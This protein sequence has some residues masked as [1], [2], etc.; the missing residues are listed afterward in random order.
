MTTH[1]V[2]DIKTS[3]FWTR[4][5][6]VPSI[7][8]SACEL[9]AESSRDARADARGKLDEAKAAGADKWETFKSRLETSWK[10]LEG[11]FHKL[12]N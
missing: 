7:G 6:D 1:V 8:G 4:A 11:A 3:C 2:V 5:L 9:D 12:T 10:E